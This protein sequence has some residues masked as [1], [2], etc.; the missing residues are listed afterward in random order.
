VGWH[1]FKYLGNDINDLQADLS[2]R[3]SNKGVV[4]VDCA[5]YAEVLE[6]MR[7]LNREV[8]PLTGFFDAKARTI[9]ASTAVCPLFSRAINA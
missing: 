8:Y 1:W 3:D 4:R 6:L 5:P 2:N 7:P 9:P